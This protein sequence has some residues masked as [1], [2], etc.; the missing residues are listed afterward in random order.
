VLFTEGLEPGDHTID[1]RAAS[2]GLAVDAI[3]ILRSQS[4]S[5]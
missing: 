3:L 2:D 1:V 5:A 4:A